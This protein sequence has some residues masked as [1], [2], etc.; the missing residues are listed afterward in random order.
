MTRT[1]KTIDTAAVH[2]GH[3][4]PRINGAVVPP[5]FKSTTYEY[6]GESDYDAIG[7]SRLNNTPNH[8]ALHRK[9]AALEHAEAALVTGSG[10][11]AISTAILSV[12]DADD[13]I[14]MVDSPYGG[15][16]S[17]AVEDLPRLGINVSFI[18]GGEPHGWK[19]KLHS[20]TRVIYVESISNPLMQVPDLKAVVEFAK[21]HRLVSMIDNTFASPV[22]FRP[23][24]HGFDLSL[25]SA[26]KY[27]NGH[28]DVIAGVVAGRA[29]LVEKITHLLN[30]LGGT[31]DPECCALL[32]RGLKTLPLRVRFQ[33]ASAWKIAGFLEAHD[34][35]ETVNYPG[36]EGSAGHEFAEALFDGFGGML[37]FEIKGG[38]PAAERFIEKLTIP[39]HAVSLGGVETL[40]SLP[41]RTAYAATPQAER[42]ALGITEGL[43]RLSIGIEDPDE[44][45]EDI[46]QALAM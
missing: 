38:H 26:T 28:T 8:L 2:A 20:D 34:A 5:I 22:N 33:N 21:T 9:L 31:L 14:L 32:D 1:F 30:H 41:A 3:P 6:A 24:E 4:L 13:H 36:L 11:A 23:C 7:Y 29:E 44:L 27:L 39:I 12:C 18:Q 42:E 37:S 25:H 10:M 46:A 43:I 19:R 40:I 15:T 16:R 45:I 17:L 35:V